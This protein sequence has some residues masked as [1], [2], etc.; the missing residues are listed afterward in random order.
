MRMLGILI[1]FACSLF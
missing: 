1:D